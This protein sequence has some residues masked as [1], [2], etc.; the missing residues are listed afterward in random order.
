[1]MEAVSTSETS[2]HFY[3]TKRLNKPEDSQ[4]HTVYAVTA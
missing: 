4:F 1:M 2:I 3:Q